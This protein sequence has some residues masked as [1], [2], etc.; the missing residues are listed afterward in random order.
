MTFLWVPLW[1]MQGF[2]GAATVTAKCSARSQKC[3]S[4]VH[5]RVLSVCVNTFHRSAFGKA[6]AAAALHP[7]SSK[8]A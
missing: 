5:R 2:G 3:N 4:Y 6:F 1:C 8:V 7:L